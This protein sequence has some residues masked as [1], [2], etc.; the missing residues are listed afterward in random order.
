MESNVH[1]EDLPMRLLKLSRHIMGPHEMAKIVV[2]HYGP[3]EM[4]KKN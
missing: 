2:S 4:A 3:H 1:G